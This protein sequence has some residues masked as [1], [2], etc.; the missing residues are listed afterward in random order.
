MNLEHSEWRPMK[1]TKD[2]D[3]IFF[4]PPF[5]PPSVSLPYFLIFYPNPG[6]ESPHLFSIV[7]LEMYL[8]LG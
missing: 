1:P 2:L 5:F 8:W 6:F 7:F 4:F 3:C